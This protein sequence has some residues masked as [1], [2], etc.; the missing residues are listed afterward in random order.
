MSLFMFP[1]QLQAISC[2]RFRLKLKQY[3]SGIDLFNL[4]GFHIYSTVVQFP[5][6]YVI[7]LFTS[8]NIYKQNN[9]ILI[10]E[11]FINT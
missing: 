10:F 7:D 6:R 1:I 2:R 3:I 9:L 5:N 8:A 11:G 4:T